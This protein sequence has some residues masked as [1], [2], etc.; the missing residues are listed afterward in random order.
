M[1]NILIKIGISELGNCPEDTL[2]R[3]WHKGEMIEGIWRYYMSGGV[4]EW[5]VDRNSGFY[6]EL[7]PLGVELGWS[8]YYK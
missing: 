5:S 6:S 7:P 1:N 4:D 8:K 3:L 2:L